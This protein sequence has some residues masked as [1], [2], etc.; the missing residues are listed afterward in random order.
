MERRTGQS[1]GN[2]GTLFTLAKLLTKSVLYCYVRLREKD[3]HKGE[4]ECHVFRKR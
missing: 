1:E 2:G 4:A 3:K